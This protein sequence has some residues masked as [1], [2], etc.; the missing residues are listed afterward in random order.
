MNVATFLYALSP[1]CRLAWRNE[2]KKEIHKN[3][4][5]INLSPHIIVY[6][7][8]KNEKLSHIS[9]NRGAKHVESWGC[10]QAHPLPGLLE[11]FRQPQ[12]NASTGRV[13]EG[14][15]L[16][17]SFDAV[18][19][20]VVTL[21]PGI[22]TWIEGYSCFTK[23]SLS[24][25]LSN[26]IIQERWLFILTNWCNNVYVSCVLSVF[27]IMFALTRM[28]RAPCLVFSAALTS[29]VVML[30]TT[31]FRWPVVEI[32][33]PASSPKNSLRRARSSGCFSRSTVKAEE[34]HCMH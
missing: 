11:I 30:V 9:G 22:L 6:K 1:K 24:L 16:F 18:S 8:Q 27:V 17:A 34:G 19:K 13:K 31:P 21:Q 14:W 15:S 28:M 3:A 33:Y 4:K 7:T 10:P 20:Q 32:I 2:C 23:V 26:L 5:F 29:F 12:Q 25:V